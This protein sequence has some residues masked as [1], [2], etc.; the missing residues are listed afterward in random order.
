VQAS[1]LKFGDSRL[2]LP[3]A[4]GSS[5]NIHHSSS[6]NLIPKVSQVEANP[7]QV[8]DPHKVIVSTKIN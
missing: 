8:I 6:K 1:K 7:L 5:S 2:K 3:N 4:G